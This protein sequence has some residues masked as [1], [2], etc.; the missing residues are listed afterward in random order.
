LE[1]FEHR[2]PCD[3][4]LL[5]RFHCALRDEGVEELLAQT[6]IVA[7]T[8]K[9]I[10]KKKLAT[11][12]VDSTVQEKAISHPTDSKLLECSGTTNYSF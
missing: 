11:V 12:I 1:Y 10:A 2:W 8:L 7:L 3:P 6:I 9:L 5:V 4:S